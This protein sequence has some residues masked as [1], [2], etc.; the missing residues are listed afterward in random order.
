MDEPAA[1]NRSATDDEGGATAAAPGPLGVDVL[2]RVS[3]DVLSRARSGDERAFL[4]LYRAAQPGLLRYL[5][6]LVGS[7]AER[8]AEVTWRR[9]TA[10]LG[11]FDG[12]LEAFRAWVTGIGRALALE[13]LR[14]LR[15][16]G[17]AVTT[18]DV[19]DGPT[20]VR[21]AKALVSISELDGEQ[22]E[23]VALC[24]VVGMDEG[25][26]AGVL[27]LRGQTVRQRFEA[28][29]RSLGQRLHQAGV[30]RLSP[31][32]QPATVTTVAAVA[33]VGR[34]PTVGRTR[35]GSSVDVQVGR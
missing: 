8:I 6:V 10:E 35:I 17:I 12:E 26:A 21:A 22:A 18:I 5:S 28:G 24:A 2:S 19:T 11:D 32:D 34:T 33:A 27:G 14:E 20:P 13:H 29:L 23:A 9:V 25:E 30:S 7:A 4:A 3:T 1:S 31:G 16:A 15:A